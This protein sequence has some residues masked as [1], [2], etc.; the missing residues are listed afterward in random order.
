MSKYNI[1]LLY[2]QH[3]LHLDA[4]KRKLRLRYH[5]EFYLARY[6]QVCSTITKKTSFHLQQNLFVLFSLNL[7]YYLYELPLR[8]KP[9]SGFSHSAAIFATNGKS[10]FLGPLFSKTQSRGLRTS[11]LSCFMLA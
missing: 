11:P 3:Y 7:L 6:V 8:N 5:I 9:S 4:V 1:Y 10:A 2:K